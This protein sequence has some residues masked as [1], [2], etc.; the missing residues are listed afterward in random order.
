MND[1]DK[2]NFKQNTPHRIIFINIYNSDSKMN[3]THIS[4]KILLKHG[5]VN[6]ESR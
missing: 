3:Y 5:E 2:D 1:T 4:S 6:F